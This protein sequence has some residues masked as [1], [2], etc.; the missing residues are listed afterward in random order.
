MNV[1]GIIPARYQSS[2]F[3]GKPLQ[4]IKGKTMI[5]R[6]YEQCIKTDAL[7][8]VIVATDDKRIFSHVESFGGKVIM[9]SLNHQSGTDRCNEVLDLL[10]NKG[11]E[12]DVAINV[13]GD[14]PFI[15]PEQIKNLIECFEDQQT[16]IATLI[17]EISISDELFNANCV[18]VVKDKNHNAL[19]FS[20]QPIPYFRNLPH[21]EW[22]YKHT[23]YKH[24]GIYGFR[25]DVLEKVTKVRP[26][27]LE[28]TESLEQLRWIENGYKIK[29]AV[30]SYENFA[31]DTPE[32]LEKIN[33]V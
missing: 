18:K 29:L 13:Q 8:E 19:Y 4:L 5:Q 23:Y 31:V 30:T 27:Q 17:K 9:T 7:S 10:K 25:P 21:N 12:Y 2:R 15:N 3:P 24:I 33:I 22:I 26:S 11:R 32:D 20:R 16:Q 14:E 6:V 1:I 28:E